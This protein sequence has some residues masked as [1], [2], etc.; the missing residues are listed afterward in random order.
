MAVLVSNSDTSLATAGG[1]STSHSYV[2]SGVNATSL[3]LTT[4][5]TQIIGFASNHNLKGMV[6]Q[7]E[8]YDLSQNDRVVR[9]EVQQ[10]YGACTISNGSPAVI[11]LAGHG[12]V[13]GTLVGFVSSGSLPTGITTNAVYYVRNAGLNTFNISATPAGALINTSSA[14]SGTFTLWVT[15]G[16][17][18]KSGTQINPAMVAE[19]Y[20]YGVFYT[21]FTWTA[22][23]VDTTAS[24]YKIRIAQSG[25]TVGTWNWRTS[26]GT[27]GAVVSY[28]NDSVSI[29]DN[30]ILIV[31]NKVVVDKSIKLLGI[32][33]GGDTTNA[34]AG[35]LC[36]SNTVIAEGA[37]P[38]VGLVWEN[39]F[40][41]QPAASY[42]LTI[43]GSIFCATH[44]Q[45]KVGSVTYPVSFAKQAKIV[46]ESRTNG[47]LA[48]SFQSG[49]RLG[50]S[51]TR[52]SK[53][54]FEFYGA[55][56]TNQY[57]KLTSVASVTDTVLN[58]DRDVSTDWSN[59]DTII[60]SKSVS[61]S[62]G[63]T[64]EHVIQSMTANTITL[65]SGILT[66]NRAA[67]AYILNK[68]NKYGISITTSGATIVATNTMYN[69]AVFNMIGVIQWNIIWINNTQ[70]RTFCEASNSA[71]FKIKDNSHF[72]GVTTANYVFTIVVQT[73][74]V[75]AERNYT[76]RCTLFSQVVAAYY[77]AA[78]VWRSGY[79]T[80]QDNVSCN[81]H[82]IV[83]TFGSNVK[84]TFQR[85]TFQ[86]A[87]TGGN[88]YFNGLFPI[89]KNNV[90]WG[91]AS[92]LTSNGA[93]SIGAVVYADIQNNTY[94]NCACALT[95]AHGTSIGAIANNEVFGQESANTINFGLYGSGFVDLTIK[96]PTGT[97][98]PDLTYMDDVT[99]GSLIAI[100]D[101]NNVATVDAVY[102]P[103]GNI[104]R[105][106]T[107]LAD[108]TV[109]PAASTTSFYSMRFEP[110]ISGS[111]LTVS[112]HTP[113]GNIQGKTITFTV[114]C[115]INNANY[116]A[117]THQLPR[118]TIVYD[119]GTISY[120]QA[121]AV[122]TEQQLAISLPI[123]TDNRII[124]IILSADTDA[125]GTDKNVYFSAVT[126][127]MPAAS[128]IH[129]SRCN[130]W[131][132]GL[133]LDPIDTNIAAA[134]LWGALTSAQTTAG[135][136]GKAVVDI[137]K[138][139]G[140]IPALL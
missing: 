17:Q 107:S 31:K 113:T 123:T 9:A 37:V 26:N 102:T 53:H 30:D 40:T 89:I 98:T 32:A 25:G 21:D 39:S 20:N 11:T 94:D 125:T 42:T 18:E 67:G 58:V 91:Y 65:T 16:Y 99:A 135:T 134:D 43:N 69:M 138:K 87:I 84:Y 47:T 38:D 112:F 92:P 64:T 106:G 49:G 12:L 117:G 7:L 90:Y 36:T 6:L 28:A 73:K 96:S 61:Q 34:V 78:P 122:T 140:L 62:Q 45:F 14:G 55:V 124:E 79:I 19:G 116:Y 5:R 129:T 48:S 46:F 2:L 76:F 100:T 103:Y 104:I 8:G 115:K 126:P 95:A 139:T 68:S 1:F 13:D 74:G 86:N 105:C 22:V 110:S 51:G 97:I 111:P 23:A 109:L 57:C 50:S 56:P 66:S 75:I 131:N 10:T 33:V 120:A 54:A 137:D 82:N 72:S 83:V 114:W 63:T 70:S 27:M 24:K 130:D 52:A 133:P 85:N 4:L 35:W 41:G 132:N 29:A 136:M 121:S 119:N 59:G 44:S 80:V 15:I 88:I 77:S 108:T 60:I 71:Q 128:D 101:N 127:Q 3:A 93:V 81:N 118:L